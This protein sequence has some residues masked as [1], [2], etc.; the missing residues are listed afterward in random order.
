VGGVQILKAFFCCA[1]N[2]AFFVPPLKRASSFSLQNKKSL[3]LRERLSVSVG[4]ARFELTTSTS[5]MW[6][7]TGL[8]YTPMSLLVQKRLLKKRAQIYDYFK[9]NCKQQDF[10]NA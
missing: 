1:K 6:R 2:K 10:L 8:R 5:Q 7:D 9:P 4:V 3:S